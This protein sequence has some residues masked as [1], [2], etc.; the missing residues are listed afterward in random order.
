MNKVNYDHTLI[1]KL[2]FGYLLL[3]FGL[4]LT[5]L[6]LDWDRENFIFIYNL[7]K[8]INDNIIS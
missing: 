4:S 2:P 5:S 8:I 6:S 1:F 7:D 3:R